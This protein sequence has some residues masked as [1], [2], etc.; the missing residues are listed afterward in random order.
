[1]TLRTP[2]ARR[3][4][5][6]A[7]AVLLVAVVLLACLSATGCGD[8]A[9]KSPAIAVAEKMLPSV[10]AIRAS[11]AQGRLLGEGSGVIYAA[12]GIIVTN[13]HVV[14]AGG[15]EP[16]PNLVVAFSTGMERPATVVGRDPLS[17]LAVLRVD[18]TD[19]P[20][21]EFLDDFDQ[22]EVGQ[23]AVALGSPLGLE[24]SVTFGIVSAVQREIP[25]AGSLGATDLVQT[26]A[27]ISPGNSGGAL[28]DA[29]ARVIGINV[30]AASATTGAQS[31]G[32]AIPSD[33]VIDVVQQ[34]TATGQVVYGYLGIQSIPITPD[35]EQQFNLDRSEGVLVG[36]V[37]PGS[38]A[39]TAGLQQGDV[40]IG[41]AEQDVDSPADLYSVL[42]DRRPGDQVDVTVVRGGNEQTL[43]VTLGQRPAGQ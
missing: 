26:D 39:A 25:V 40:I 42:R 33:V 37:E 6:R 13:N 31:I 17:D 16:A 20:A 2:L 35:V 5:R 1:M 8:P 9:G 41:I 14:L 12:D 4:T 23:Y 32:F 43:T 19:L 22:V 30:A 38:P 28:C 34:I 15:T 24:A 7:A 29:D 36:G 18:E 11:D 21:A 27:P 10:V 3:Q